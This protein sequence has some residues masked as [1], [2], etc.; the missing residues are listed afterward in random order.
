[1]PILG[2]DVG[3]SSV[4]A[5]IV[6]DGR[7][8]GRLATASFPTQFDGVRA[9]VEPAQ[10]LKA[11]SHAVNELGSP[12]KRADAIH[13][14]VMSP[15]WI[16]MDWTGKPLTPVVTHQDR[17]SVDVAR[18][19]VRK[20]GAKRWLSIAGNL[21]FPGGIS[22]TTLRWFVENSPST[23]RRAD[24][25][26]HLNTFLHR[27]MTGQRVVDP[28]NASFMGLY[29][30]VKMGG[31]SQSLCK[32]VSVSISKLPEV[33]ESNVIAG[34][35]TQSAAN[36]FALRQ[37]TPVMT[38]MIDTGAAMLLSGA[39]VGQLLNVSGSTDVLALCTDRARPHEKLLTRAL[40][41]GKRW[42]S[43]GTLA[44]SG[45]AIHWM[46]T[47]FFAEFSESQFYGLVK[48]LSRQKSSGSDTVVFEPYL[49]GE[50]TSLSQKQAAFTGL[51]LAT[52]RQEMLLAVVQALA[53]ASGARLELLRSRGVKIRRQ[54]ITS[55]GAAKVLHELLYRDWP[56]RWT[57][58]FEDEASLRG[59]SAVEPREA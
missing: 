15:A 13:F 59:L 18:D 49:A 34:R 38:G 9:E 17:R 53:K 12:A 16:A 28:S 3:S 43:V 46:R 11:I 20:V 47:Q 10:I 27:Q 30:T 50:R 56:G 1:M 24:L 58:Q 19:L 52:T 45:S 26:G 35:I 41:I 2:L 42:L 23:I 39:R 33:L 14:S 21:P 6:R 29:E 8:V 36:R 44:A 31:W 37:G 25:I 7:I 22:V 5:G 51:T 40:G 55:G 32:T 54:V 4:K 57:F 48:K